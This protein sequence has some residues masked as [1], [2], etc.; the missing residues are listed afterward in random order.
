MSIVAKM[1]WALQQL[2]V[3]NAFLHGD[4]EEKMFM[5]LPPGFE[6]QLGRVKGC[7]QKKSLYGFK[8]SPRA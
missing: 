5:E 4:L 6:D 7:R 1:D 2:D 8:Q 3:K